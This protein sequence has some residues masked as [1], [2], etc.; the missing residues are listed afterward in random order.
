MQP[1][2]SA[3]VTSVGRL[4]TL[5]FESLDILAKKHIDCNKKQYQQIRKAAHNFLLAKTGSIHAQQKRDNAKNSQARRLIL[6]L[7]HCFGS[8]DRPCTWWHEHI[9]AGKIQLQF[10][11]C[12]NYAKFRFPSA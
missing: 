12:T 6:L 4:P 5:G 10:I 7:E 1:Q 11:F 3:P 8:D 9:L 2:A